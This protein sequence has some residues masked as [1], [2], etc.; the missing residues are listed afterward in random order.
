MQ[1]LIHGNFQGP[2]QRKAYALVGAAAP[3]FALDKL[4]LGTVPTVGDGPLICAIERGY[5]R[6][7]GLEVELV[8]FQGVIQMMPLIVR[9]DL[10]MIGGT[11]SASYFNSVARGMPLSYFVN[12]ARSP[13]WHGL[14]VTKALADKVGSKGLVI[15]SLVAPIWGGGGAFGDRLDPRVGG[16]RQGGRRRFRVREDLALAQH[17]RRD[18]AG[19]LARLMATHA[20]GHGEH[21]R[22][23]YEVV[24]VRLADQPHIGGRTPGEH[25]MVGA[26]RSASKMVLPTCTRSPFT[27]ATGRVT[28]TPF[29][30][31]PLVLPRSSTQTCSL[32]W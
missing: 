14:I 6:E 8:P 10:K 24:F 19:H 31:V 32:R 27:M 15:G 5:F 1:S 22:L 17:A 9:G 16:D 4:T 23:R 2:M 3:A 12:R 21:E 11:L 30:W 29:T 25:G 7:V 18:G 13:V 26:H 28:R 20:V